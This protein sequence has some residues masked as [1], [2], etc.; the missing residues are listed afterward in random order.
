MDL[1]EFLVMHPDRVDALLRA[2]DRRA[3]AFGDVGLSI[4][5]DGR[6]AVFREAVLQWVVSVRQDRQGE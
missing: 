4:E 1:V 2:L 5:D 6:R 3:V